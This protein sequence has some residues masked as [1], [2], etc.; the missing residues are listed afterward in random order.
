MNEENEDA[1]ATDRQHDAKRHGQARNKSRRVP[2]ANGA[3]HDQ[4]IG[5]NTGEDA[6]HD[7]RDAVAHEVPQDAGGVLAGDQ[8]QRHQHH[9]KRDAHHGHHRAGYRGQHPARASRTGAKQTRPA[10]HPLLAA[11]GVN[12][13]QGRRDRNATRHNQRR[14]KPKASPQG[15]PELFEFVHAL[16]FIFVAK[17]NCEISHPPVAFNGPFA[18]ARASVCA[19]Q[20]QMPNTQTQLE[21]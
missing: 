4:A 18:F 16:T 1:D 5:E 12:L 14:Q 17:L 13:N 2:A 11:G 21:R 6:E 19:A 9:R 3:Q 7:L 20:K 8:R 15:A 10:S